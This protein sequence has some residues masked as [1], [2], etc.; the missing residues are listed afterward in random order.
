MVLT[1]IGAF[2]CCFLAV[3]LL[4]WFSHPVIAAVLFRWCSMFNADLALSVTMTAI[5]TVLSVLALPANLL[6]YA[7]ISYE[8]H[9]TEQLDWR[10]VFIALAIVISAISIGLYCSYRF[11]S[12]K[13]NIIA[14]K[15]NPSFY[16]RCIEFV[17]GRGSHIL[18]S[19]SSD[20]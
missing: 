10:S 11:H 2:E 8:A 14:N 9:V 4:L 18:S 13:F 19:T 3:L 16:Q 20:R 7:N 12:Y 17:D 15:V 6:L 1:R 5:S